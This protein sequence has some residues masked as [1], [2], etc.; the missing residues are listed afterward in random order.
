MCWPWGHLKAAAGNTPGPAWVSRLF[1][2]SPFRHGKLRLGT[3]GAL[4]T[5]EHPSLPPWGVCRRGVA[6]AL[7]VSSGTG[8]LRA[9]SFSAPS[10]GAGMV[11][12]TPVAP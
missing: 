2:L 3:T 7:G 10:V 11:E 6:L 1:C 5:W 8:G 4:M 12:N 9:P